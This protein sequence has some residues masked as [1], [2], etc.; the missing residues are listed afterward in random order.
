MAVMPHVP[1]HPVETA[2]IVRDSFLLA[3]P[4]LFSI[5]NPLGAS[6]I[7]LQATGERSRVE[8]ATIARTVALYSFVLLLASVWIGS[9]V[10]SFFG[11]TINALRVSGGMVVAVRAW[12]MLQSPETTEA[13]REKQALEAGR[14]ITSPQWSDIAFFPLTMPFTVG[15]GSIA[16]AI[17]LSSGDAGSHFLSYSTG[18]SLAAGVVAITVWI[19]YAYAERLTE[20]LG[21]TGTRILSRLAALILLCIGVQI[22][23]GGVIGFARDVLTPQA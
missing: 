11:V 18:I 22:A 14:P 7:F 10:L 2:L 12:A 13:R 19:A 20:I 3:F 6:I 16:V 4:A 9:A 15:P 23:A 17:T 5:V 1:V 21:V 8:R